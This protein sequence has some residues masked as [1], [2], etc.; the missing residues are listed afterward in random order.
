MYSKKNLSAMFSSVHQAVIGLD[1]KS[2]QI[3]FANPASKTAFGF[4]LTGSSVKEILSCDVL[5]GDANNYLCG[6]T[7]LGHRACVSV[8][9]E[10]DVTLLFIDFLSEG[11]PSL[12]ISRQMIN[13]LRNSAMGIKLSADRCFSMLEDGQMPSEKHI[14]VLYHSYYSLLRTL[15]QIDSADLIGRGEL[16]FSP[17]HT[18]LVKLCSNVTDIVSGLCADKGVNISFKT[19]KNELFAVV[20]PAR[21]EQLLLNLFANSLQ[22]TAS[23]NSITLSLN[24]TGSKIVISLDD[25]GEG[26]PPESV[27]DIFKLPDDNSE[28]ALAQKGNGLGL[29]IALGIT[30]QH[31][32][33]LL[34]ESR[35]GKGTC[36]RLM[37]PADIE[38]VQKFNSPET[39]YLHDDTPL[40][41]TELANVLPSDSYGPKY[42]D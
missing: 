30:Q 40:V 4:D 34:V 37:L 36:I 19:N 3:I 25:D 10:T 5:E 14:S 26:I 6:T 23:G 33:V 35:E 2:Y 18:D 7:V 11:K 20:D 31:Q 28:R 21:I 41:L 22:H 12:T 27:S 15:I 8:V 39:V 16:P 29:Y 13:S 9:K 1:S 38:I 17:V 24:N 42:E 32:G